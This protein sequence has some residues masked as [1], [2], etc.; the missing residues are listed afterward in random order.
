VIGIDNGVTGALCVMPFGDIADSEP[1]E[2]SSEHFWRVPTSRTENYQK[3]AKSITRLNTSKLLERLQS[4][5][6]IEEAFAVIERPLVNPARFDATL[7]AVRC[8][9]ATLVV[10][11]HLGIPYR[12]IDSREWQSALLPG[13]KGPGNLKDAGMEWCRK[14]YPDLSY[15]FDEATPI[16]NFPDDGDAVCI[17][18][19]AKN[20]FKDQD[21]VANRNGAGW[22]IPR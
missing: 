16:K 22:L 2:P 19:Y 6:L 18:H 14:R 3:E 13:I 21:I 17:A 15:E 9:E 12:F 11:E 10:L 8:F 7:S 1:L 4:W 5:V 20:F